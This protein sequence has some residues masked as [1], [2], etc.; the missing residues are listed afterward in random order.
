MGIVAGQFG[1]AWMGLVRWMVEAAG[2]ILCSLAVFGWKRMT[3]HGRD[4][5]M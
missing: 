2:V 3:L 5:L 1:D 4:A